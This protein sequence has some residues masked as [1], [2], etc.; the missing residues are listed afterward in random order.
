MTRK[1]VFIKLTLYGSEETVI[2]NEWNIACINEYKIDGK[3]V[4]S[5]IYLANRVETHTS[6]TPEDIWKIFCRT[7]Y[8]DEDEESEEGEA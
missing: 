2:I 5:K 3:I 8:D 6:E 4:G 7:W 1:P